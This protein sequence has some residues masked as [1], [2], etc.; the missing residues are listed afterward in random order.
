MKFGL[1][2]KKLCIINFENIIAI[3]APTA[4][5]LEIPI[6]PGSTSGFLKRPWRIAP[7]VPKPAPISIARKIRGNLISIITVS[8]IWLIELTSAKLNWYKII[9]IISYN[10]VFTGPYI[11]E[12]MHKIIVAN[13]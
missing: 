4:A 12:I 6:K 13:I 9:F 11:R 3:I 8:L 10:D 7:E 2:S 5:P 1:I